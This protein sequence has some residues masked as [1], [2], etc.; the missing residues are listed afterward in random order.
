[1]TETENAP[2]W[3]PVA[4]KAAPRLGNIYWCKFPDPEHVCLPE[5]WKERPIVIISNK[6]LRI[7]GSCLV[8]PMSTD[9]QITNQW[10]IQ[11]PDYIIGKIDNRKSWILCSQIITVSTS[12][13]RQI[14]GTTLKLEGND[15]AAVLDMVRSWIP[16][17]IIK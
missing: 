9:P 7:K 6:D 4:I 17:P 10:V 16:V 15:I 13:L 3:H 2:K 11:V 1:M 8:A 12:R 5:M 14:N